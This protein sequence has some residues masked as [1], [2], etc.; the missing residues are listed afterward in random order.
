MTKLEKGKLLDEI[1]ALFDGNKTRNFTELREQFG[2]ERYF[3]IEN[4]LKFLVGENVVEDHQGKLCLSPKGF[5]IYTDLKNLGYESRELEKLAQVAKTDRQF[6]WIFW[7]TLITLIVTIY[8]VFFASTPRLPEPQKEKLSAP[9][10]PV[11]D[12]DSTNSKK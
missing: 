7:I 3:L 8:Q 5:A 10:Q 4:H 9:S 6:W 12:Q 11:L 1:L 2:E